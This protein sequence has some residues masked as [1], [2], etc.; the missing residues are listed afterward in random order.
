ML[1]QN[2]PTS[3]GIDKRS[4][5]FEQIQIMKSFSLKTLKLFL[6]LIVHR[7]LKLTHIQVTGGEVDDCALN[8]MVGTN[9]PVTTEA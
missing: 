8:N 1:C 2:M 9:I 7:Y 6:I 5:H 3:K 4:P